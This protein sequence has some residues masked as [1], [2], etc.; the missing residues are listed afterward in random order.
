MKSYKQRTFNA[1]RKIIDKYENPK[2]EYAYFLQ[3][4]CPLCNIYPKHRWVEYDASCRGCFMANDEGDIGCDEFRSFQRAYEDYDDGDIFSVEVTNSFR[5]RAKFFRE[6]LVELEA[7]PYRQFTRRWWKYF[8][9][10]RN[11]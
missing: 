4:F 6:M 10:D 1:I 7:Y 2:A 8:P 5:L 3:L 9:I 11:R